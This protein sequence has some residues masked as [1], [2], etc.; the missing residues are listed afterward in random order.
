MPLQAPDAE[1]LEKFLARLPFVQTVVI[2]SPHGFFGQANV[3]GLPDTGG[4]VR[5]HSIALFKAG[6]TI[7]G[8]IMAVVFASTAVDEHSS[9]LGRSFA[10]LLCD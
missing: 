10:P 6:F 9:L 5:Q 8:V 3:L 2:L 1:T 7:T 4:Q